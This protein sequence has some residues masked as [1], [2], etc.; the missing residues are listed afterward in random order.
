LTGCWKGALMGSVVAFPPMQDAGNG[1]IHVWACPEG[2]FEIG[3][4]SRSGNSWGSFEI[5]KTAEAAVAAAH[6][7]N[8]QQY[9]GR[10]RVHLSTSALQA[11]H[12]GSTP[13]A[14]AEGD[15]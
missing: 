1:T 12:P 3:H 11:L 7:L 15:F 14:S 8:R 5:H 2:D 4:E 9:E 10:A 6:R 13:L